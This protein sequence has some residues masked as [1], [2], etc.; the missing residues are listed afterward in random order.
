M[1]S[2]IDIGLIL[3]YILIKQVFINLIYTKKMKNLFSLTSGSF[4]EVFCFFL[5]NQPFVILMLHFFAF[6]HWFV[7]VMLNFTN[8]CAVMFD[9][10]CFNVIMKL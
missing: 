5:P 10:G 8:L 7:K 3:S 2:I 1:L 9:W 6:S 4:P